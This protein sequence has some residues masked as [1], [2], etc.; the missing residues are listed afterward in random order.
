MKSSGA[1]KSVLQKGLLFCLF[2]FPVFAAGFSPIQ[3]TPA[4]K[5]SI[6][7]SS[8]AFLYN[9]GEKLR[10]E[11]NF[12]KAESLFSRS[13]AAA[14]KEKNPNRELDALIS[15]GLI[16]WNVGLV[17]ESADFFAD[18]LTLAKNSSNKEK[19]ADCSLY[20]EIYRL[21]QESK[22]LRSTKEYDKAIECFQKAIGLSIKIESL[23]HEV[24]CLRQLSTIYWELNNLND[25][26]LYSERALKIAITLNHK[27]EQAY[28][29]NNIGLYYWKIDSYS[30]SLLNY[31][32]ALSLSREI[33]NV[34]IQSDCLN[35]I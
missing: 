29:F 13:L 35:N 16:Y 6:N 14:R 32:K 28:C 5:S 4:P 23:E 12:E 27:K 8:A 9:E 30:K 20:L 33:K 15:L 7:I 31:E 2:F 25:Y 18:A 19:E 17:K 10:V 24:K 21:Y 11:G 34:Q 1:A 3:N 26:Y 22:N